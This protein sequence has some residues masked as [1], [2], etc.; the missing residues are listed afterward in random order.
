MAAGDGWFITGGNLSRPGF[1]IHDTKP[2]A[3]AFE[4]T[5][6]RANCAI[7]IIDMCAIKPL[8]DAGLQRITFGGEK[9]LKLLG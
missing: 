4:Y 7:D 8:T 6:P 2:S 5:T 9:G 1:S 3:R